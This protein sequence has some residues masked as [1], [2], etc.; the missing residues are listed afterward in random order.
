MAAIVFMGIIFTLSHFKAGVVLLLLPFAF[1]V[2]SFAQPLVLIL[3]LCIET[4][5][6]L[7]YS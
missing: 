7:N 5:H 2:L 3:L 4:R 6:G 1:P